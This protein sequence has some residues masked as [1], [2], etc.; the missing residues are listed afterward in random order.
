[1][2][3]YWSPGVVSAF[4]R[5]ASAI[6]Q[7]LTPDVT[8]TLDASELTPQGTEGQEALRAF[9]LALATTRF[10]KSTVLTRNV[11]TR[12]QLTRLSRQ[13]GLEQRVVFQD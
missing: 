10:A 4:A 11:L 1:M 9:F 12:M 7:K 8:L 6:A 13:C 2:W 3:G 5:E